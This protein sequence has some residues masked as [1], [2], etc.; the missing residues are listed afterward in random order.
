[1]MDNNALA[2]IPPGPHMAQ[3]WIAW[4]GRVGT[5]FGASRR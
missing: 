3:K 2:G 1:M 5:R 4:D